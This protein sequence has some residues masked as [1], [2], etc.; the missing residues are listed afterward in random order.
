[1][2]LTKHNPKPKYKWYIGKFHNEQ[3][4]KCPHA[5]PHQADSLG[6]HDNGHMCGGFCMHLNIEVYCG[7]TRAP[8][9]KK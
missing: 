7:R 2:I 3:C 1:M 5:I 8:R 6:E 4:L 9:K